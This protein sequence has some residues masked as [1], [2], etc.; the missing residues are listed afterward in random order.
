[1]LTYSNFFWQRNRI[2]Q[3]K[4]VPT[5]AFG[6][7]KGVILFEM[8]QELFIYHRQGPNEPLARMYDPVVA[9]GM[10]HYLTQ[11]HTKNNSEIS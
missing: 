3:D 9:N 5:N 11:Q 6:A 7:I 1:M 10:H 8:K 2:D 4:F